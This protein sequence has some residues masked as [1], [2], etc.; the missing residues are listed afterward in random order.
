MKTFHTWQNKVVAVALAGAA[1]FTLGTAPLALASEPAA[2][3]G[4]ETRAQRKMPPLRPFRPDFRINQM[5]KE[6]K[7]TQEQADKLKKALSDFQAK[8][9][10]E[11]QKFMK[12]LPGKTGISEATLREIMMPRRFMHG[13]GPQLRLQQLVKDGSVTEQEAAALEKSFQNHRPQAGQRPAEG[14]RPDPQQMLQKMSEETGISTS[15]L[16][17]I[18]QHMHQQGPQGPQG[19][20][21][22]EPEDAQ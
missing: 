12:S 5:V 4:S 20:A 21:P 1:A 22:Q 18:M 6:G 2:A 17:E 13:P 11:R 9:A 3:A 15:R 14:Q 16:Q 7:I 10:K 19:E 8:Q